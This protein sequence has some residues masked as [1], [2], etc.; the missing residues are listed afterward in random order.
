V[1]DE[2]VP[3]RPARS[4]VRRRSLSAW[5][6]QTA[7]DQHILS[8]AAFWGSFSVCSAPQA[9]QPPGG[10]HFQ[11]AQVGAFSTGL[12]SSR[13]RARGAPS[14][15]DLSPWSIPLVCGARSGER[16]V[17]TCVRICRV[18]LRDPA[19]SGFVSS[20]VS[21][22]SETRWSTPCSSDWSRSSPTTDVVRGRGD[23]H[24]GEAD[25]RW[26][27]SSPSTVSRY[28]R[29][30][31]PRSIALGVSPRPRSRA[32]HADLPFRRDPLRQPAIARSTSDPTRRTDED[33]GPFRR[34][35]LGCARSASAVRA[36][37][38]KLH[39]APVGGAG[40]GWLRHGGPGGNSCA[41]CRRRSS[42]PTMAS[43][44]SATITST[45]PRLLIPGMKAS[46]RRKSTAATA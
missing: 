2:A 6:Q 9:R 13:P 21:P 15:R 39:R 23:R 3:V 45:W 25:D 27:P 34:T 26:L 16:L 40:G 20:R 12:D 19:R 24:P 7:F 10:V 38:R 43:A 1:R 35:Q 18:S 11:P 44:A 36:R 42:M 31:M 8:P 28:V 17:P 46:Q 33:Q 41:V 4:F 30:P 37:N 29:L 14:A 22:R 5:P 32:S